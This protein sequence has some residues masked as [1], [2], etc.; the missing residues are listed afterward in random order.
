VSGQKAH[1]S[2]FFGLK[3]SHLPYIKVYSMQKNN[4]LLV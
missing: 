4:Y 3:S 1:S 2:I